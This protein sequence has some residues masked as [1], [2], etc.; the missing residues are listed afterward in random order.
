MRNE[1]SS[2]KISEKIKYENEFLPEVSESTLAIWYFII[3][4]RSINHHQT[5]D[6]GTNYKVA[7]S[8]DVRIHD[9]ARWLRFWISYETNY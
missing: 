4:D 9:L 3:G 6:V 2:Q 5:I 7:T 8:M 1:K